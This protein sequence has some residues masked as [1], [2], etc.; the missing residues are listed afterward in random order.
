M[1]M[2]YFE[3]FIAGRY[4]RTK[5]R[6]A[7]ISLITILSIA[8]IALGVMA[9][10]V[11]LGVMAGFEKDLKSRILSVEPHLVVSRDNDALTKYHAVIADISG[12]KGVEA[13]SPFIESQVVLRTSSRASGALLK[14]IDPSS[15]K[16]IIKILDSSALEPKMHPSSDPHSGSV[17][18]GMILGK[19]LAANLGALI[20]DTIYLISPRGMLSPT[21]HI[22]LMKKFAVTGFF[23]AGMYEYDGSYAFIHLKE[24]Q[25]L[26]KLRQG[27][28]GIS[29]RVTNI[30]KAGQIRTSIIEKLDGNYRVKTWMEMNQNLF[31][32]LKLEKTVMFIILALIILVAALNIAGSIVMM[33]ME[34]KKEIATL[35]AMGAKDSSIQNIF[36][37]KGLA[38]GAVGTI[39]GTCAGLILCAALDRYQF[40]SLPADVFYITTLPVQVNP[41]D[42]ISIAI[43]AMIICLVAAIYPARHASRTLPAEAIRHG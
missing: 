13:A 24:A 14:G 32:A 20:G 17:P 18:P 36:I 21:G 29:M 8:G 33:V 43:A 16:N 2:K 39:F 42:I 25:K 30:F 26:M 6:Q 28:T 12:I 5:R 41:L 40:I 27:V 19:A 38:I 7:F 15:A 10:I 9:L 3:F 11:V 4:L 37:L 31:S 1:R 23:E 34:K 35:K 22:P